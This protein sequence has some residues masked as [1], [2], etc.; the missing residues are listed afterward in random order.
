VSGGWVDRGSGLQRVEVAVGDAG[1]VR[2]LAVR[3]AAVAGRRL[4]DASPWV[5]A[6]LPDGSRLHAVLPPV[7]HGAAH[8]SLRIPRRRALSLG[9]LVATGTVPP[10][11]SPV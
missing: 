7:V 2:R 5:D 10:A 3:L 4:D 11:W 9:D 1:E 8:L 6:R